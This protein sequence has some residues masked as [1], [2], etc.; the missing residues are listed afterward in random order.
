M[1]AFVCLLTSVVKCR[2]EVLNMAVIQRLYS[3]V[4]YST[5]QYSTVQCSAVQCSAV[6]CSA[7]QCSTVQYST[8]QYSTVQYSKVQYSFGKQINKMKKARMDTVIDSWN[9][10]L[11]S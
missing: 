5:V 2:N 8:V 9:M 11:C 1:N 6:Q 7:V 10:Q 4:Q 3:T